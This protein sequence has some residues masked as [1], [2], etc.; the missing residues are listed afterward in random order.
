MMSTDGNEI[1]GTRD[2]VVIVP[3]TRWRE[4]QTSIEYHAEL[5]GLIGATTIFRLLNDPGA[6]IGPQE[7]SIGDTTGGTSNPNSKSIQQEVSTAINI[8]QRARPN[9]VTPLTYHLRTITKRVEE[10][11]SVLRRQGQKAVVVIATDGLPSDDQGNVTEQ[12]KSEFVDALKQLQRLPVWVV[13]RLCTDD[14]AVNDYYNDLDKVLELPLECIDDFL[15]EAKEIMA[16]NKWLNYALPL[17]R[18]REMGYQH[19][20]FDLLDE[21]PLTKDELYE[22][23]TLLFGA[24]AFRSAPDINTNWT[25]FYNVLKNVV[26]TERSE[27]NP[28]TGRRTPWIDMKELSKTYGVKKGL[29]GFG[30]KRR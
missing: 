3:C 5:A 6:H 1:R 27:W 14:D 9:G 10:L 13:I 30:G 11:E 25:G 26:Q 23:L 22:F 12:V 8:V 19:R 17:H 15:G 21:R 24:S 2:K 4:L 16:V 28:R 29:F 18:C 7:F 20:L